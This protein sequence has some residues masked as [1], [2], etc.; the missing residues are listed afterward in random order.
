MVQ[1]KAARWARSC[2]NQTASVTKMLQDLKWD[3]L[4]DRRKNIRLTLLY[5]IRNKSVDIEFSEIGLISPTRPSR[6][7]QEQFFRLRAN[8]EDTLK[9]SFVLRTIT[10]WSTPP[11]SVIHAGSVNAFKS[12]LTATPQ[13]GASSHLFPSWSTWTLGNY[14]PDPD[15][16]A[17]VIKLATSLTMCY[18]W[19]LT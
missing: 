11:V 9:N 2:F 5:N 12:R 14:Y 19:D 7:H 10:E 16:R 6:R 3:D 18:I 4:A 8:T 15:P 17:V 13:C 1:R